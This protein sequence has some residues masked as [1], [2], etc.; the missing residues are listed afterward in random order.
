VHDNQFGIE[1][2]Y[3][4]SDRFFQSGGPSENAQVYNNQGFIPGKLNDGTINSAEFAQTSATSYATLRSTTIEGSSGLKRGFRIFAS[5]ARSGTASTKTVRLMFGAQVIG[6][7]NYGSSDTASWFIE[8]TV[9]VSD[10]DSVRVSYQSA[11]GG[12]IQSKALSIIA[13]GLTSDVV[14]KVEGQVANAGD[15][16]AIYQFLVEPI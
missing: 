8:A 6:Q 13:G 9:N 11:L 5:G 3:T 14:V 15:T 12:T 10:G 7:V 4:S 16:I 1:G 2:A